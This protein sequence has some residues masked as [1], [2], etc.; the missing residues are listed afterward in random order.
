MKEDPQPFD[1]SLI[2]K[3]KLPT[4]DKDKGLG[5]GKF[6]EGLGLE[7]GRLIVPGWTLLADLYYT[8]I[9]DPPGTNLNNQLAADVGFSH[10]LQEDLTLTALLEGS[11]ALVSG[12][13]APLD[14]RGILD[15]KL[16]EQSGISG[17]VLVGLS[18][19]SA[20]YG[21]SLGG[22]YRF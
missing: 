17:G 22:S 4:A 3:I 9:G 13:P 20:D 5:T 15:Y 18:D 1:L 21:L 10:P 7:F 11:N 6:D 14:L 16:G 2:A 19:G 12:Q 8:V